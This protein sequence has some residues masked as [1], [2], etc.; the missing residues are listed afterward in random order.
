MDRL[1]GLSTA[2]LFSCQQLIEW[3]QVTM[4]E[5][6]ERPIDLAIRAADAVYQRMVTHPQFDE[7]SQII[8]L[9]GPGYNGIDALIISH[10]LKKSNVRLEVWTWSNVFDTFQYKDQLQPF[11]DPDLVTIAELPTEIDN[12]IQLVQSLSQDSLILDGLF[13]TGLN[14]PITGALGSLIE[15]INSQYSVSVWSIDLPSGMCVD[16][17]LQGRTIVA[18]VVFTIGAM[19]RCFF[20]HENA[21]YFN[22][23]ITVPL[24]LNKDFD[25]RT[26]C[27]Y[28]L[29]VPLSIVAKDQSFDHKYDFGHVVVIGGSEGMYGAASLA[30]KAAYAGGAGLVSAIV[31][32]KAYSIMQVLCPQAVFIVRST[33]SIA[34]LDSVDWS[35]VDCICVGCGWGRQHSSEVLHYLLQCGVKRMVLDADAL[36]ML[37]QHPDLL[38]NVHDGCILTPHLGE[39]SRLFG[40]QPDTP[41]LWQSVRHNAHLFQLNVVLKGKYSVIASPSQP[42]FINYTGHES[43]AIAGSGDVLAGYMSAR[44]ASGLDPLSSMRISVRQ[45]GQAGELLAEQFH[46]RGGGIEDLLNILSKMPL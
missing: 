33:M 40:Q 39:Y 5:D 42:A 46:G 29:N 41:S 34:T 21:D 2:K 26:T 32:P 17:V 20:F 12:A 24:S 27:D 8:C 38:E 11:I 22:E 9:C 23:L 7:F 25:I 19:K 15:T 37:S 13:G 43:L 44:Y 10:M 4:K 1:S 36:Y 28:E 3:D 14:R 18:N 6:V 30:I 45:H 35:K 31:D 16:R